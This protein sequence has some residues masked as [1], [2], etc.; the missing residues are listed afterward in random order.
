MEEAGP[1]PTDV[2]IAGN[3]FYN[4]AGSDEH[5]DVNSV[6]DVVVEDNVFFNDFVGS[7]RSDT[8][9]SSFIV[10]KDSNGA[11]DGIVGAERITVR[12]NVF[13]HWE[14][15]S[16]QGFVRIGEDGT[17]TFEATDVLIENNLML[18][19]NSDQIRSPLQF[20]GVE[21]VTARA[22]TI[23]G[24]LPAKE[25]GFRVT[26]AG[27][28]PAT[29]GLHIHNNIWSD[30]TGTMGDTFN[31]G[32]ATTNLTFDNNLFFNAGN[33]FPTSAESVVE[34]SDDAGRIV[35]DPVLPNPSAAILPRWEMGTGTFSDGSATIRDAFENLVATYGVPGPGS[36]ALDAAD[37]AN[38]P[39]EDILGTDRSLG[40]APDV[41][42][43]EVPSC[44]TA[45]D[46][47]PCDDGNPCT[48]ADECQ[49]GAC[50][51]TNDDGASC[52]DG[53][54][55]T[56]P[57]LCAGGACVGSNDDGATCDDGDP[58]THD[59]ACAAGVCAAMETPALGCRVA[60]KGRLTLR[61]LGAADKGDWQW[62]GTGT[63]PADFGDPVAGGDDFALCIYDHTS[64]VPSAAFSATLAAGATC[65]GKPCWKALGSKGFRYRSRGGAPDGLTLAKLKSAS[66]TKLKLK[67][68]GDAFGAPSLPFAQDPSVVVQLIAATGSC[69]ETTLA[70]PADTNDAAA[71]KDKP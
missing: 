57:D 56:A 30:P 54:A 6:T 15:S 9:T 25:Y 37:P 52:D 18:G 36:A 43:V 2:T 38:M 53:N 41:G 59:D 7:G 4:Q 68:G 65:D 39:T 35:G 13:L 16:G 22:N 27:S 10:V 44:A 49:S 64:A 70:A 23:H 3:V 40:G 58:C 5:I 55:C 42:A 11:S 32:T 71:F 62:Q 67:A 50:S 1:D 31:R 66:K 63:V 46:G 48:T 21:D 33:A 8:G 17:A 14:G 34:V 60:D 19:N 24:N 20:Q 26:T 45:I 51:G 47:T 29:D 12:R 69:W 61:E 28:N